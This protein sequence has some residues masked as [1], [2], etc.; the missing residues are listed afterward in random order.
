MG[1]GVACVGE[2]V[3]GVIIRSDGGDGVGGRRWMIAKYFVPAACYVQMPNI[4]KI[5]Y[6][7]EGRK[8]VITCDV[9]TLM[10]YI[11]TTSILV[12]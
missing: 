4:S 1:G 9:F 6:E 8:I 3:C 2:G 10:L 7:V 11:C 12:F 5:V